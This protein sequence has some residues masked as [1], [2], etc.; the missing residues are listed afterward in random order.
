LIALP[1]IRRA[2]PQRSAPHRLR[3]D[4]VPRDTTRELRIFLANTTT[5]MTERQ[6]L[7]GTELN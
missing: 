7:H 4:H 1:S 3:S 6:D 2:Q 5:N